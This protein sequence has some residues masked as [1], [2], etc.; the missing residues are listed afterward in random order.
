MINKERVEGNVVDFILF[1]SY[2]FLRD[3]LFIPFL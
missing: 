1:C 2:Y 3:L